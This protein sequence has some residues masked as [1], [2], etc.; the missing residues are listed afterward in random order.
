MVLYCE[1][2]KLSKPFAIIQCSYCQAL[3]FLFEQFSEITTF[4][5]I[6]SFKRFPKIQGNPRTRRRIFGES[7]I[8]RF[9]KV[10]VRLL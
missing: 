9:V 1:Y 4:C 10:V 6:I 5:M 3:G 8:E 2:F 7:F